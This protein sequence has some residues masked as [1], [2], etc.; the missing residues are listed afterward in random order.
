MELHVI[1]GVTGH[2]RA[3]L[4]SG[5]LSLK[6]GEGVFRRGTEISVQPTERQ[7][8]AHGAELMMSL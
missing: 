1:L 3:I 6:G 7:H 4:R 2:H 8:A 5:I